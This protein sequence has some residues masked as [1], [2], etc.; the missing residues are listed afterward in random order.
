M[1]SATKKKYVFLESENN[2]SVPTGTQTIV[3]V[4]FQPI[5]NN[6][7]RDKIEV[8]LQ[9]NANHHVIKFLYIND[10]LN[11]VYNIKNL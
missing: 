9:F 3:K 4:K 2:F 11:I 10:L 5:F 1:S 6:K 7:L 8:Y